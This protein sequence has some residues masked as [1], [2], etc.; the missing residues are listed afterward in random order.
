MEFRGDGNRREIAGEWK[1]GD[2][3]VRT[4]IRLKESG[5]CRRE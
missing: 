2:A 1:C 5:I 3:V 4:V